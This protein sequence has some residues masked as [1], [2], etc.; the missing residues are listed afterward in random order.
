MGWNAI[1]RQSIRTSTVAL[2]GLLLL[3]NPNNS[4]NG[5]MEKEAIRCFQATI[6][7]HFDDGRAKVRRQAHASA[8]D[9]LHLTSMEG[10]DS[11]HSGG[12]VIAEYLVQYAHLILTSSIEQSAATTD[13]KTTTKKKKRKRGR[14]GG[15]ED[16]DTGSTTVMTKDRVIRLMHLLSFLD[17]SISIIPRTS[18]R[19]SILGPDL[20]KLILYAIQSGSS[21]DSNGK[22]SIADGAGL[23]DLLLANGALTVLL[24]ILD[25]P[26]RC[27]SSSAARKEQKEEEAFRARTWASLIQT[28]VHLLS[29]TKAQ[30]T[31][32]NAGGGGDGKVAAG[33]CRVLYARCIVSIAS[34]LPSTSTNNKNT[35]T[36]P[37]AT[38]N[39]VAS[40]LLPPSLISLIHCMGDD[41]L[42][43]ITTQSLCAELN[44]LVRSPT[45]S[46][47]VTEEDSS[48]GE[49][50]GDT[51]PTTIQACVRSVQTILHFRFRTSWGMGGLSCLAALIVSVV[52]G[53]IVPGFTEAVDGDEIVKQT[54]GMIL[55][56]LLGLLRLHN[57]VGGGDTKN[58]TS[59]RAIED[60]VRTIAN[61]VG[62][63]F[64]LKTVD[65][66]EG[67]DG[68][69]VAKK[70]GWVLTALSPTGGGGGGASSG[71]VGSGGSGSPY[72]T[73]LAFFQT[74]VLGLARR[75]DVAG[76]ETASGGGVGAVEASM[77]K[78]RVVELWSLFPAFCG[79]GGGCGPEDMAKSLPVLVQ[80]LVRAMGDLR[81]PQLLPIICTGLS[82]LAH[83]KDAD[84]DDDDDRRIL[85][86]VSVKLL[87]ALFK[88]VETLHGTSSSPTA[89]AADTEDDDDDSDDDDDDDD[90]DMEDV[91]KGSNKKKKKLLTKKKDPLQD[92]NTQRAVSVT[93]TIAAYAPLAPLPY[94]RNL[95]KKI[96]QRL[97]L[98]TDNATSESSKPDETEKICTLLNLAQAILSSLALPPSDTPTL[99]L[100][101]RTLRPLLR[102]DEHHPRIQKRAYTVLASICQHYTSFFL[103]PPTRLKEVTDLLVGSISALHIS[104]RG[105]RLRCL[106]H[107]TNGLDC[108][109]EETHRDIIPN[110]MGEVLLSLKDANSKTRATA[111]ELLLALTT[112]REDITQIL[113]MI[114]AAL[115]AQTSHMRSAAVMALSRLTFEYARVDHVLQG[116]LPSVL[117]TVSV[118]FD[119][120]SR[121]VIK[122][123]IGFVRVSVA[124]MEPA[125]LEPLLPEL[126]G[127][128]MKYDR[129]SGRFR[130]KIKIILKRLVKTYGYDVVGK[131]VPEGDGRLLTHMRK[132][133]ERTKR[134]KDQNRE[135]GAGGGGD[136]EEMMGEEEEDSDD[137]KTFRTGMT[138]FTKMTGV[139]SRKGMTVARSTMEGR[140]AKSTTKSTITG[141]STAAT[142]GGPRIDTDG[143]SKGDVLD[144]LDPS[145][146]KSVRFANEEEDS[147]EFSDDGEAMEFDDDGKLLVG[148][149]DDDNTKVSGAKQRQKGAT[150]TRT[151]DYDDTRSHKKMRMSKF[152]SA[153][154]K[155]EETH[156]KKSQS[157]TRRDATASSNAPLGAEFKSKKAGGD[158]TKKGQALEPYAFVPLDGKSYTKKNRAGSVA[159]MSTVVRG[160]SRS[161]NKRRRR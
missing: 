61:G 36:E 137:G 3:L 140:S 136:F 103:S 27:S 68:G 107:I 13:S 43:P 21:S 99:T 31:G 143:E 71:G 147:D 54:Q 106:F 34:H 127:G 81:Y 76:D 141:W 67:H 87:P 29:S 47:F 73:K 41:A 159:Q 132:L 32:P 154:V 160:G 105:M 149:D 53:R 109:N 128:L 1:L 17:S 120:Q 8:L 77:Q 4:N 150:E 153:K 111:Y 35:G 22:S 110:V 69:A 5:A 23:Y 146:N 19:T 108:K 121:E 142:G 125:E 12:T 59:R 158:V 95:F 50:E 6:L 16:D 91:E 102:T 135:D 129:G 55:P 56:L 60:A 93:N 28:N 15:G 64:F 42:L 144:M 88:L 86:E 30:M 37:P 51:T 48:V 118:L 62:L 66:T 75:C 20:L 152:E 131:L 117:T 116:L 46:S 148:D 161:G 126:I 98:A 155:R 124:A 74:Y 101:Y 83:V 38:W 18:G 25:D 89:V 10:G 139:G 65:L 11:K 72:R 49:E 78:G 58:K 40:K 39:K 122:A 151:H 156:L 9:L 157:K 130:A 119:E 63:E 94:L 112:A 14:R 70:R 79:G 115:G 90:D 134:R 145:V 104:A 52:Q 138:G 82:Q 44:R 45:L 100:L 7:D 113:H 57:D 33:E 123:V 96:L 24:Q 114:V 92:M 85:S 84:F 97:L 26:I 2:N 133:A 80:I